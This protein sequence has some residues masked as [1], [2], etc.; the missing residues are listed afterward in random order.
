MG[1]DRPPSE[2]EFRKVQERL[3]AG[4]ETCRSVMANYRSLLARDERP[5]EPPAADDVQ[6]ESQQVRPTPTPRP[7]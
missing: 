5:A 4:I 1:G 3:Q 6:S 7:E 2:P